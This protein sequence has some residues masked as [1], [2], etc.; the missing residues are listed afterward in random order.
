[1]SS[2]RRANVQGALDMGLAPGVL[3][4]RVS[5]E[6][7][8]SWF[9]ET[10]ARVPEARGLD[11]TGMLTAAADGNVRA[12]VLLG[13]D[14]LADFP[15]RP[16]ARRALERASF[17]VAVDCFATESTAEADVVLPAAAFA[18]RPG[19]TTNQ[20]GRISRLS[21][22]ITGPGVAWPDWMIAAELA[23]RLG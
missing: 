14:P 2:L 17:V 5:L 10:W 8:T 18:E 13:A 1:L 16:L 20:E 22:K 21:Q 12:L 7:G 4:G 19:S 23:F 6:A 9:A 15:D 11:T 3:P